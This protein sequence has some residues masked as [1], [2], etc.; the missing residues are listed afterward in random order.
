MDTD[1]EC[2]FD[3]NPAGLGVSHCRLFSYQLVRAINFIHT[4]RIIH[5]D[6]NPS[7]IL[8]NPDTLFVKVPSSIIVSR[9]W[10]IL[11]LAWRLRIGENLRQ[12]FWEALLVD[13][14]LCAVLP[15]A[16]SFSCYWLVWPQVCLCYTFSILK[17]AKARTCSR[18]AAFCT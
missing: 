16:R 4:S 13:S 7:N 8:V 17:P 11:S 1:L 14:R 3:N 2:V 6:I 12:P 10:R 9:S 5:R 18:S 15:R